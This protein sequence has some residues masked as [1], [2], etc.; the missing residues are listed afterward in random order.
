MNLPDPRPAGPD[1]ECASC[2]AKP[3]PP[4]VLATDFFIVGNRTLCD[5]CTEDAL[6]LGIAGDEDLP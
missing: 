1:P 4:G 3:F 6:G 5:I 2:G